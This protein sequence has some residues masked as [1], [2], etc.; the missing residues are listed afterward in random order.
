MMIKIKIGHK[1]HSLKVVIDRYIAGVV[2]AHFAN[3]FYLRLANKPKQKRI[4]LM[5]HRLNN[6]LKPFAEWL[7]QNQKKYEVVFFTDDPEYYSKHKNKNNIVP[8]Y[9]MQNP[10]HL[11][12]AAYASVVCT[13]HG[14]VFFQAWSKNKNRPLLIE[15]RHGAGLKKVKAEKH[16]SFYDAMFITSETL[17]RNYIDS[18]WKEKQLFMTGFAQSD[19]LVKRPK[20]KTIK[21]LK[22]D[23]GVRDQFDKLILYAPTWSPDEQENIAT[24]SLPLDE[25]L[26]KI[27]KIAEKHNAI[28]L[29][30]PHPNST[31]ALPEETPNLK[32]I[33]SATG[34]DLKALLHIVDVLITDWSSIHVDYLALPELK[35]AIFI[36]KN[37]N[38]DALMLPPESRQGAVTKNISELTENLEIALSNPD[39]YTQCYASLAADTKVKIWGDTL[40]GNSSKRYFETIKHLLANKYAD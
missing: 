23:S 3:V 17:K 29:M 10:W 27:C 18:G 9:S 35:P 28:V 37:P 32:F 21:Q 33:S 30:L 13:S 36:D 12:L 6:N 26:G 39:K 22:N 24:L 19:V 34:L 20:L 15:L 4:V 5:G 16:S 2:S 14:P 38:W 25:F 1:K 7:V 11:R 31:V 40:D 8:F